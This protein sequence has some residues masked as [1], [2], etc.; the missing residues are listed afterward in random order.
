MNQKMEG[1]NFFKNLSETCASPGSKKE[2]SKKTKQSPDPSSAKSESLKETDQSSPKTHMDKVLEDMQKSSD[3]IL[4]DNDESSPSVAAFSALLSKLTSG[5]DDDESADA[6]T[7]VSGSKEGDEGESMMEPVLS[8]LF[9]KDILFPSL[10]LMLDNYDKYIEEREGTLGADEMN[11]CKAQRAC[12][13]EMCD[14]YEQIKD[15]D[16][17]EVKAENL[18]KILDLL[19]KCGVRLQF[20]QLHD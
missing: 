14:A 4:N 6:T 15:D 17:K 9:S 5:I 18:K 16:S 13:R 10:K 19:E 7:S 12:I 1:L 20:V 11:K 3:K 2:A 8:M